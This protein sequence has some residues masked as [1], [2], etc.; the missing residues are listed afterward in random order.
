MLIPCEAAGTS[1]GVS[2]VCVGPAVLS[3]VYQA[4]SS[5]LSFREKIELY[6]IEIC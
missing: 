5:L 6:M 4:Y 1:K 3:S 2:E